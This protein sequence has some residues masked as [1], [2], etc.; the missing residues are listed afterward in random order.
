MDFCT[1]VQL[2]RRLMLNEVLRPSWVS[3]TILF[4]WYFKPLASDARVSPSE[5]A[6]FPRATVSIVCPFAACDEARPRRM[7]TCL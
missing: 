6:K 3:V 1:A 4:A 7:I 5:Q 2:A